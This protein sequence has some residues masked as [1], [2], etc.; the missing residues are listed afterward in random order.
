MT[1]SSSRCIIK[2]G[3]RNRD[4]AVCP[5]CPDR[6]LRPKCRKAGKGAEHTLL[7]KTV[8]TPPGHWR[9]PRIW[10]RTP[11]EQAR[12]ILLKAKQMAGEILR[13]AGTQAEQLKKPP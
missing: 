5:A 2:T 8:P 12:Q 1:T 6:Y 13:E 4:S 9:E 11:R 7:G 3:N 10:W